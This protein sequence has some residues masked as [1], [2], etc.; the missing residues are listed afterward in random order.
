MNYLS[1]TSSEHSNKN[2]GDSVDI[3]LHLFFSLVRR[4]HQYQDYDIEVMIN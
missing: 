3:D 4:S 2:E 1:S